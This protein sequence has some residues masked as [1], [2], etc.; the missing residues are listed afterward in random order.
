MRAKPRS[1]VPPIIVA[2]SRLVLPSAATAQNFDNLVFNTITPCRVIDTR[3]TSTGE[4]PLIAG[5]TRGFNVFGSD[6]S[7]QGGADTGCAIPGMLNQIPQTFAIAVNISAV[8]P[9]G[10]GTVKGW[11]GDT[12]EPTRASIVT[13]QALTP[14]LNIAN[15]IPLAVRTTGSLGNG[16]DIH[17]KANGAGTG[18]VGDVVGYYTALVGGAGLGAM[19]SGKVALP[20]P[21]AGA[22]TVFGYASGPTP[23]TETC[24]GCDPSVVSVMSPNTPCTA[25]DLAA[26]FLAT[27]GGGTRTV[28]L[29]VNDAPTSVACSATD[30]NVLCDSASNSVSIP[31]R[32]ELAVQ[33]DQTAGSTSLAGVEFG[34]LCN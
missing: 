6:L 3:T 33:I 13:Y 14:N 1:W 29:L 12:P 23:A 30:P 10:A 24:S 27:S 26:K 21:T 28:T 4:H 19:F 16:D 20:S 9:Q 31:P 34:F 8:N 22:L 15:A 25:R 5:E 17:L 18:I 7:N 32:S 2:A 11:A